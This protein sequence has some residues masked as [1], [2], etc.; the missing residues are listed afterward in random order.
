MQQ[1]LDRL[2]KPIQ[3]NSSR[4]LIE[5]RCDIIYSKFQKARN[6][7]ISDSLGI[8][9]DIAKFNVLITARS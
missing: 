5:D 2:R 9:L 8:G 1:L 3:S 4:N 7:I 6:L